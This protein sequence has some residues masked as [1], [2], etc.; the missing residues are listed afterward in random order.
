MKN[1]KLKV[2]NEEVR[3]RDKLITRI[4]ANY[5]NWMKRIES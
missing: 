3:L 5:K 4:S 1:E 2:K